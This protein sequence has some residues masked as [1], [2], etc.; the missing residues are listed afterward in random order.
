MTTKHCVLCSALL[1]TALSARAADWR[2][3]KPEDLALKQSK[4]DPNADAEALFRD[5]RI[6]N[7][8]YGA[9]QNVTTTYIRFKIFNDRGREKYSDVKIEYLGKANIFDVSGRTI[10][11]DGAVIDL[12]KDAIF[13]KVEVKKGGR[14]VKAI[15]FALPSVE[16]G[17]IIEYRWSQN[18]GEVLYRYIPLDV[19]SEYPVDEVTF[20]LKPASGAY[21]SMP[22]MRFMPFGC[23]PH[24]GDNDNKGFTTLTVRNVP[25]Y[26]VEPYSPPDRAARQWILVY[27]EENG[28]VGKDKYWS[29]V[30]KEEY[31]KA[32]EQIKVNGEIKQAAAEIVA[33]GA[34]DDEK[35]ALLAEY[36][37][38]NIKNINGDDIT[39]EE[40]DSYKPN[41][42]TAD[43]FRR[44]E[45]TAQD[46]DF[47]FIALAQAAGYEARHAL[48]A[49]RRTFLFAPEMQSRF[50]LNNSDAAV[51]INGKWRFYDVSDEFAPP[52][53]LTWPEQ[54]VYALIPDSKNSEWVQ[55]PLL[56][57]DE[58]K[59]QR[60]AD[61]TLSPEG[62]LEGDIRELYWGNESIA[63]RSAHAR[64]NNAEREEYVRA[65]IRERF[66][67]FELSNIKVTLA[68]DPKKPVGVT[69]RLHVRGYAQRTGKRLFL[70]PAFFTAGQ[71]AYFTE[72]NRKN[73]IFFD[74][75]WSELDTVDIHLPTGFQLDHAEKPAPF[76]FP[77]VGK[78][79]ANISMADATHTLLYRRAFLFGGNQLPS[80]DTKN[81]QTLKTVFDQVH[82]NDEHMLT[83]KMA[84][85]QPAAQH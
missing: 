65:K 3:I 15:S 29:S 38:K 1:I 57:S 39:T 36:C 17:S 54:G 82:A 20:H 83:L 22:A 8:L 18:E 4:T 28:N 25:A 12:K 55:T 84:D 10:H 41:N 5:V 9:K 49:D 19:Q 63:W 32:K 50:F 34:N 44:K 46:I 45:G 67:D 27:Y 71:R 16:P 73:A 77:P 68:P 30:G 21:V 60:I 69:Y 7:A 51:Q 74:Y 40:G 66:A 48:V 2:P 70:N 72:A 37:R 35:L 33:K 81:Y 52:G 58:T 61:V 62:D 56:T 23:D 53:S 6:E 31:G 79:V 47:V 80:F 75:P 26:H 11:P 14:K 42:N 13:D 76:E 64:Q 43:T 85:S 78:Y 24:K 59:L